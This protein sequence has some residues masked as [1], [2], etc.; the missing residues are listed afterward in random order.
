MGMKEYKFLIQS[1]DLIVKSERKIF[2]ID[3]RMYEIEQEAELK[4]NKKN[5]DYPKKIGKIWINN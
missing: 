4:S 2:S 1:R 5:Y 3:N